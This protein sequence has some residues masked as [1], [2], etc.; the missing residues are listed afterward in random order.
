MLS[1]EPTLRTLL[2]VLRPGPPA[3]SAAG[4][5]PLGGPG[6]GPTDAYS[7]HRHRCAGQQ[8]AQRGKL[9]C[10]HARHALRLVRAAAVHGAKTGMIA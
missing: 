3:A 1:S 4:L 5:R 2:V 6:A 9:G 10:R 8:A 7:V